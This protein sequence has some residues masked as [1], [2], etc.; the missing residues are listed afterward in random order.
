[1]G[2]TY[3]FHYQCSIQNFFIERSGEK[4]ILRFLLLT[5]I[6]NQVD[7][8]KNH[9]ICSLQH[10][11]STQEQLMCSGQLHVVYTS[12]LFMASTARYLWLCTCTAHLALSSK[13]SMYSSTIA[14]A[15]MQ[16]HD[17]RAPPLFAF[18]SAVGCRS[19]TL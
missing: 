18:Y 15:C 3:S 12:P 11:V 7:V 16:D 17:I 5:I 14:I 19:T 2:M 1:M 4:G 13:C 6:T 10:A 8:V 9:T